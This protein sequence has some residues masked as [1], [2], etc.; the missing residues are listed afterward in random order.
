MDMNEEISIVG[1]QSPPSPYQQHTWLR[2]AKLNSPSVH[3]SF[4]GGRIP[5]PI[6]TT[7]VIGAPPRTASAPTFHHQHINEARSSMVAPLP[8]P[9]SEDYVETPTDITSS[10]LSRLSFNGEDME[11]DIPRTGRARS[12]AITA[13]K[14]KF[15]VG[16]RDDCDKCRAKVP[17]HWAHF[18]PI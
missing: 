12:G 9:I 10:Q 18:L 3:E 14:K 15:V 7:F 5:T 17:G 6:H 1:S 16:Y 4:S 13:E 8:S 11:M 2:P